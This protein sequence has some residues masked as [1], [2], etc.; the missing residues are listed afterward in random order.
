MKTMICVLVL[1]TA[2]CGYI[3]SP[4]HGTE[5]CTGPLTCGGGGGPHDPVLQYYGGP[6]ISHPKVIQVNWGAGT[7]LPEITR[8]TGVNMASFY[9]QLFATGIYD[10]LEREYG[11]GR[12]RFVKA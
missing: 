11:V 12:G 6:L 8:P 4:A 9:R 1:A 5:Q 10:W 7:Y 3:D 2:S